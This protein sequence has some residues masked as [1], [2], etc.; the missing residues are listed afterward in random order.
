MTQDSITMDKPARRD[1]GLAFRRGLRG[2]CP[3]CGE[4]KIFRAYLKVSDSCAS[5]GE[6]LHHQRA[7]DAPPYLVISI[8]AHVVVAG[9]LLVEARWED[10]PFWF[11]AGL[12]SA[13]TI[14]M[15]LWLLPIV[16]GGLVGH[17]WALRMHGFGGHDG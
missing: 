2:R 17:Q 15:S 8:V 6:E 3:Q 4:G 12:W 16:K 5:C 14:A 9:V 13:V 7:D 11:Q 1:W 10:A